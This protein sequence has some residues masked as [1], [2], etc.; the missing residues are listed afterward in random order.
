LAN[1][2]AL[3]KMVSSDLGKLEARRQRTAACACTA[4]AMPAASTPAMP[5]CLMRER[6]SME[7]LLMFNVCAG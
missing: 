5:A 6:R 3:P 7:Q 1:F 4:G 2:S